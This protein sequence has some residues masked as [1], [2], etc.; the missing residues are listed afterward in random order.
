M[1]KTCASY[2]TTE[3]FPRMLVELY[4]KVFLPKHF[5]SGFG[6]CDLHPLNRYAILLSKL[7]KSL[8]FIGD[9]EAGTMSSEQSKSGAAIVHS[10]SP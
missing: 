9:F 1:I 8:P 3:D 5:I 7:S 2:V 10:E 6:K 4:D